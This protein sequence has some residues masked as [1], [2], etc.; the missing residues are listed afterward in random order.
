MKKELKMLKNCNYC[1][2]EMAQV[3]ILNPNWDEQEKHPYWEV[4]V[5]CK[6]II[7]QQQ[8]LSF[9]MILKEKSNLI[10]EKM[11]DRIIKESNEEIRKLSHESGKE[12]STI[13]VSKR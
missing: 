10:A 4:C 5:T 13:E 1:G 8:K 7:E 6:K 3:K 12:T 11:A 9:G 2:E